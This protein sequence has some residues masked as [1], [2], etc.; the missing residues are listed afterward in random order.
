MIKEWKM[1]K[2]TDR[3]KKSKEDEKTQYSGEQKIKKMCIQNKTQNKKT[4]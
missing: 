3:Q 4:Q 1:K 2:E